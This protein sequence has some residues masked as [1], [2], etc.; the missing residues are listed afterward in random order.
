MCTQR[1][2]IPLSV[3]GLTLLLAGFVQAQ[4]PSPTI[5]QKDFTGATAYKVV[6]IVDGDT[7][8]LLMDGKETTVR[9]IG[10]DTPETVHPKKPVQAYGKEASLFIENLLKKESVYV[11]YEAGP[12][13]LDKYGRL[14]AYLFRAPDGLFVNLEIVRQGYGHAYTQYPFQYMELFRFYGRNAATAQKGLWAPSKPKPVTVDGPE[15]QTRGGSAAPVP[16]TPDS[17]LTKPSKP[18]SPE[19]QEI[20]VY[21]TR[22]GSKYHSAGCRH[23]SKSK[24]PILLEQ[25]RQKCG[26]CSV[27]KP[28][29]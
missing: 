3:V 22:S 9:L 18:A 23:L 25:A 11:E 13:N 28:P 27:C 20:T 2:L 16:S 10:V 7:V 1:F 21:V 15:E 14:L 24:I 8:V 29:E 19:E 4:E 6:R 17:A 5:P 26:P 12:S